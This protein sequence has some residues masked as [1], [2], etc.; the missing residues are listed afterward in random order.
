MA[1]ERDPPPSKIGLEFGNRS[2]LPLHR[3]DTVLSP[4]LVP[5]EI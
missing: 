2:S 1:G 5:P 3:F 4:V